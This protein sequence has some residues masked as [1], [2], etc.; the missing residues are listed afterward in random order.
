MEKLLTFQEEY[1]VTI[2]KVSAMK[3]VVAWAD[4]T[5]GSAKS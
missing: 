2:K 1:R 5:A 3:N 4:K